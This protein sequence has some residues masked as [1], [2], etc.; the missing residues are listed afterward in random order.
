MRN[1]YYISNINDDCHPNNTRTEFTTVLQPS[2]LE[3]LPLG[4]LECAVKSVT[5]NTTRDHTQPHKYQCL[6][7]KSNLIKSESISSGKWDRLFCSIHLEKKQT[8]L[9]KEFTNPT[10]F[11]TTRQLL[12][13][14]SF[15]FIDLDTNTPPSFTKGGD[16]T[17]IQVIVKQQAKRM[18]HPFQIHLDSSCKISK[19]YFPTNTY[20]DFTVQLPKRLEFR[21][22]WSVTLKSI[23]LGNSIHNV[24]DCWV[25]ITRGEQ[26]IEK[27]IADGYYS[28]SKKLVD[29]L[30]KKLDGLLSFSMGVDQFEGYLFI[31]SHLPNVNIKFSDNLG[32]LL[33]V[34]KLSKTSNSVRTTG[35]INLNELVPNHFLV[36]CNFVENSIYGEKQLPILKFLPMKRAEGAVLNYDFLYSDYVQMNKNDFDCIRIQILDSSGLPLKS[37]SN[38]PTRLQLVFVNTNSA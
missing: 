29:E 19:E 7:L 1:I 2:T 37:N 13:R 16:S 9:H 17:L 4:D 6:G 8:H 36:C 18:K 27:K 34:P 38:A 12:S 11:P 25:K 26:I 28:S 14:A 30:N 22:N 32:K 33:K 23:S 3:Y 10:F 5:I 31:N 20:M 21:K 15:E 24:I 35:V